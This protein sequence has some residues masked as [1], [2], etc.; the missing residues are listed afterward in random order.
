MAEKIKLKGIKKD[1]VINVPITGIH[2]QFIQAAFIRLVAQK[3]TEEM[4][5]ALA[6][7]KSQVDISQLNEWEI[8][9]QTLAI[10]VNAIEDAAEKQDQMIEEEIELPSEN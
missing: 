7:I 6:K 9:V 2:Y 10:L 1:A 5:K 8:D 4:T 3:G